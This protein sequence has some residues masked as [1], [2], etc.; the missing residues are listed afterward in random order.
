MSNYRNRNVA[1]RGSRRGYYGTKMRNNRFLKLGYHERK[2]LDVQF[3]KT[4]DDLATNVLLINT[5]GQGSSDSQRIGKKTRIVSIHVRAELKRNTDLTTGTGEDQAVDRETNRIL[6][7]WD[8]QPNGA[9][10]TVDD[11][12]RIQTGYNGYAFNNMDNRMRFNV[13][14]DW[15]LCTGGYQLRT[16][17]STLGQGFYYSGGPEI[18]CLEF[19]K[20]VDYV[21]GWGGVGNQIAD[22]KTGA[23]FLVFTN[24]RA[25]AD[26]SLIKLIGQCRIRFVDG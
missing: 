14:K 12:I 3:T 16:N 8:K 26:P 24:A 21:T 1:P 15:Q 4:V 9:K 23:L 20:E 6:L 10:P 25:T 13:I 2:H 17:A 7:V 22:I 19:Y 18:H 11:I 5:I